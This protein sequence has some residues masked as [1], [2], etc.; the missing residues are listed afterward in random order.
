MR[1]TKCVVLISALLLLVLLGISLLYSTPIFYRTEQIDHAQIQEFMESMY[2]NEILPGSEKVCCSVKLLGM[3]R[4]AI[5]LFMYTAEYYLE[6]DML[7]SKNNEYSPVVLYVKFKNNQIEIE[8]YK[9]PEDGANY[10]DSLSELFPQSIIDQIAE[11]TYND[12][13]ALKAAADERAAELLK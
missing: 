12:R 4:T 7:C 3:D 2:S 8:G 10:G 9:Q 13:E 5:Y 6:N 11:L 1:R